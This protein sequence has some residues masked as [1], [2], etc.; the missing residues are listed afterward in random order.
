MQLSEALYCLFVNEPAECASYYAR[1]KDDPWQLAHDELED[2][3]AKPQEILDS[4]VEKFVAKIK[5]LEAAYK[6]SGEKV[7]PSIFHSALYARDAQDAKAAIACLDHHCFECMT[8]ENLTVIRID[9]K[10]VPICKSCK[11]KR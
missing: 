7:K 11:L 3:L 6:M 4:A 2:C 5:Q 8:G 1:M 10:A 9:G